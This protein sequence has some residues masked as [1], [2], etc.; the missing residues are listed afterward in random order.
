M[1][2]PLSLILMLLIFTGC[3]TQ[4]K[5]TALGGLIGAT[6]GAAIGAIASKNGE[7]RTR[8]VVIGAT[9]GGITGLVSGSLLHE[10]IK[11][12]ENEAYT[13]GKTSGPQIPTGSMPALRSPKVESRWIEGRVIQNRY[14]EGHFEHLILEPTAWDVQ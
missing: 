13:R 7:A 8:N 9:I 6:G 4:N 1:N 10:Q 11:Q 12:R 3:A 14:V 2:N 5:S